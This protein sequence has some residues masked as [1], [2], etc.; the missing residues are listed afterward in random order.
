MFKKIK[1]QKSRP[2]PKRA[3]LVLA[4]CVFLLGMATK[5][6]VEGVKKE[7]GP[8]S[9]AIEGG[10]ALGGEEVLDSDVT[11]EWTQVEVEYFQNKEYV[12]D[13]RLYTGEDLT[14]PYIVGQATK[15]EK[16]R[17]LRLLRN[18]LF[19]RFGYKFN[20]KDLDKFFKKMSW[21]KVKPD[22][23]QLNSYELRNVS[24]IKDKEEASKLQ[25]A[26]GK[27]Q[28]AGE[29]YREITLLE[30]KFYI[31]IENR[32]DNPLPTEFAMMMWEGEPEY[33][34]GF[35]VSKDGKKLYLLDTFNERL[36]IFSSEDGRLLRNIRIKTFEMANAT[37]IKESKKTWNPLG[38]GFSK[39]EVDSLF[40]S[41]SENI[42][43]AGRERISSSQR[44]VKAYKPICYRINSDDYSVA[45]LSEK[46]RTGDKFPESSS[47]MMLS[48]EENKVEFS[49][50]GKM[51]GVFISKE[52]D[53]G[54]VIIENNQRNIETDVEIF[55]KASVY[56]DENRNLTVVDKQIDDTSVWNI[57]WNLSVYR[58]SSE[59]GRILN[60]LET[61]IDY[62][63]SELC[64]DGQGNIYYWGRIPDV[65]IPHSYETSTWKVVKLKAGN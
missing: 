13:K 60:E 45:N 3:L 61:K 27:F 65:E 19:A 11:G 2:D 17:Y 51:L 34:S 23:T 21:Y 15:E 32:K 36:Q 49:E 54:K 12:G 50:N 1:I 20:S 16:L 5:A 14:P 44:G 43:I 26:K 52:N 64:I 41:T 18:E 37:Q 8:V 40:I 6:E 42:I 48:L 46:I 9:T 29:G 55:G 7:T 10:K 58:I 38:F 53:N 31:Y 56:L 25:R 4:V 47:R 22:K 24:F 35:A 62:Y 57:K 33:P 59:D 39:I 30:G 63:S 28:E